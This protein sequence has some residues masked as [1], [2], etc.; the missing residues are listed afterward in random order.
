MSQVDLGE[1]RSG[2]PVGVHREGAVGPFTRCAQPAMPSSRVA[3]VQQA[4]DDYPRRGR[5]FWADRT[6][7]GRWAMGLGASDVGGQEVDAVSVEV[8]SSA[9]VVLGRSGVGVAGEDL[10]VPQRHAGV[11]GVGDRGSAP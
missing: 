4:I 1:V 9:V 8:A 11:E 7:Q 3:A 10:G 2:R 5:P 6:Q